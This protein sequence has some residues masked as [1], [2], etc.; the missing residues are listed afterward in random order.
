MVWSSLWSI[1]KNRQNILNKNALV[2]YY[3]HIGQ[4]RRGLAYKSGGL[5]THAV[6]FKP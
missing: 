4:W 3:K 5:V 6:F 1:R 2:F